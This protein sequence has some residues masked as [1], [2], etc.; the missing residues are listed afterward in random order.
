MGFNS[1]FKGLRLIFL[2]EPSISMKFGVVLIAEE[3][4][5][6]QKGLRPAEKLDVEKLIS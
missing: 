6:C 4:L 3:V 1:G 2:G 5:P